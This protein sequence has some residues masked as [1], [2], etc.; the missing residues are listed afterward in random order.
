VPRRWRDGVRGAT[1]TD[2]TEA[3][4]LY[5]HWPF[6]AARCPYCDFNAHVR[7]RIDDGR[8]RDAMLAEL[9]FERARLGTRPLASLFFG[10]GTPSLMSPASAAAIIAAARAAFPAE[11]EP[12]ITLEAN[13]TSIELV[14]REERDFSGRRAAVRAAEVRLR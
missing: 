6:C 1:S 4:S 11:A 2:V 13:P 5:V 7:E 9:A 10:G 12:E 3:L 8:W 14:A